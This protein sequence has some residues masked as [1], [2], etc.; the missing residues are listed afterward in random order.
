M[1]KDCIFCRISSGKIPAKRIY[2]NAGFFSIP[3]ANPQTDGHSLVISRQHF[4]TAL[5]IPAS[6]GSE[7]VDCIKNTSIKIMKEKNANGFNV[8]GNNFE[9]AGQAVHHVHF[10]VI[11]RKKGDGFKVVG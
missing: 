3:D 1:D 9:S 6:L 11:P 4:K 2:E 8:I 7:L 5:D 10:H